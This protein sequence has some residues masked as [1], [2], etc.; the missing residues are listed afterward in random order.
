VLK[1]N[2][3]GE[4]PTHRSIVRIVSFIDK[5]T[6]GSCRSPF[7]LGKLLLPEIIELAVVCRQVIEISYNG[8]IRYI[9][10]VATISRKPDLLKPP[11]RS[12]ESRQVELGDYVMSSGNV[13]RR[14]TSN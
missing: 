5:V 4:I 12:R 2:E 14:H 7:D 3:D 6:K 8:G 9:D 1:S 11:I 13:R 10:T